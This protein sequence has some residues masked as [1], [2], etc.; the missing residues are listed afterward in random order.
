VEIEASASTQADVST[1]VTGPPAAFRRPVAAHVTEVPLPEA[2][3]GK[4]QDAA[5][6]H[7]THELLQGAFDRSGVGPLTAQT[8]GFFEE[9]LI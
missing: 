3:T 6:S 7:P 4:R 9:M 1:G 8:D 2:R 5:G